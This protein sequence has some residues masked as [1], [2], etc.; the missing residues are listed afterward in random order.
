MIGLFSK[1]NRGFTLLFAVLTASVLLSLAL[2]IFNQIYKSLLLSSDSGVECAFYWDLKHDPINSFPNSIFATSSYSVN[3][4]G[5]NLISCNEQKFNQ[6]WT[7][8]SDLFSATTV[9]NLSFSDGIF[10]TEGCSEVTVNKTVSGDN[11][12][13]TIESRGYNI[14]DAGSPRKVER[15]IQVTY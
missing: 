15:A 9:F 4:G 6:T 10:P 13:T 2:A 11:I 1:K 8:T 12:F 3:Y 7:V 5:S 14:C